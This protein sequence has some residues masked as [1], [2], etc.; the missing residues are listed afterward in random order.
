[1]CISML[2]M[3]GSHLPLE[4]CRN[5]GCFC[6]IYARFSVVGILSTSIVLFP[7]LFMA[8][9]VV[10][11]FF[12]ALSH[13]KLPERVFSG[14]RSRLLCSETNPEVLPSSWLLSPNERES[15][16]GGIAAHNLT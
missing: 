6:P 1:M 15:F 14:G 2:T 10:R 4:W 9:V 3:E 16:H 8:M 13:P 12:T 7:S 5:V 11:D